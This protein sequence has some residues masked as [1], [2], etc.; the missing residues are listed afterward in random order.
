[1]NSFPLCIEC[2]TDAAK[3]TLNLLELRLEKKQSV[4]EKVVHYLRE[5]NLKLTPMEISFGMNE[6]IQQET[7]INDPLSKVKEESNVNALKLVDN[8]NQIIENSEDPLFD[9]IKIS[10]SGNIIDYGMKSDYDLS[11]TLKEVLKKEPFINDYQLLRENL[12]KSKKLVFLADNAGEIVF[13]K[14]LIET[15]NS[16]F[17]I[18]KIIL[19]VKKYPFMNDVTLE[20]IHNLGFNNIPNLELAEVENLTTEN[21]FNKLEI[22]I[23]SADLVIAKG[24]GN[25][26]V[27]RDRKLDLFFLFLVK[28]KV[29]EE[30]L[31]SEE[32]NIIISNL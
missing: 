26:E 12:S 16:L 27:L 1:M 3:R 10:I 30:L 25:F 23:D 5:V 32:G 31:K 14:L 15:I 29:I 20:D 21:Y 19:V 4:M 8:A 13:D 22:F 17:E 11:A 6:I 28:C 2:I 7:G 18:D 24:Q 9:A